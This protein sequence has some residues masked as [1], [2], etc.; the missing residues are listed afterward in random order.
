MRTLGGGGGGGGGGVWDDYKF[1]TLIE[2]LKCH[3]IFFLIYLDFSIVHN[4]W[5]L[6]NCLADW[7][8]IWHKHMGRVDVGFYIIK[9]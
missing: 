4:P 8:E 9:I 5:D 6:E 3:I 7:D 1:I 2:F